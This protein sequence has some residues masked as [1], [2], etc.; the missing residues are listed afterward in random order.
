MLFRSDPEVQGDG[1]G[2]QLME[3]AEADMRERGARMICLETSSQGSYARTRSFYDNAGYQQ[4]SVIADFYQPGDDRITYV[5]R[6][7]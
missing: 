3:M 6:F 5:K 2:R 1:F 4:E 7:S